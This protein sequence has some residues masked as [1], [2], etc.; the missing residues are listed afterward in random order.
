M[1]LNG[2]FKVGEKASEQPPHSHSSLSGNAPIKFSLPPIPFLQSVT[3]GV[4]CSHIFALV[5]QPAADI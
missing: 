3:F 5:F 2:K 1:A 4:R